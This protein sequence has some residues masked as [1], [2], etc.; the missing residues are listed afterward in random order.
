MSEKSGVKAYQYLK[1][2]DVNVL[3]GKIVKA[4]DGQTV[5]LSD[6]MKIPAQTLVWAAGVQGNILEGIKSELSR[7][8]RYFVDRF[9]KVNDHE[10]IYAIGDMAYMPSDDAPNGHPMQAPVAMQQGQLLAKNLTRSLEG[11]EMKPFSYLDKGSMATVGR[12]K[13]VAEI[14][15]G[16]KLG[17]LMAWMMWMFV[18]LFLIVEFRNKIVIFGNWVWNY[19]TYDRGTRLIIRPFKRPA[20]KQT[21]NHLEDRKPVEII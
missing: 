1:R 11:H 10:N 14:F 6:G 21:R 20:V 12:N 18:H 17:G 8:R 5:T 9:N 19:F 15:G 2:F 4:Y 13:A 16:F 7:D 3:I